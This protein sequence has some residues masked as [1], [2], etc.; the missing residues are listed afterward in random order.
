MPPTEKHQQI[1]SARTGK[2][3]GDLHRWINDPELQF[4]R[5]DV[6]RAWEF[7]PE[8]KERFGEE[9]VGEY[10][11]HLRIDMEMKLTNIWGGTT[12]VRDA[13]LEYFGI[14]KKTA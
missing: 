9:A 14:R 6:T 7:I 5:H 1:S 10:F 3:Y 4:A 8:V 12:E 13:A 11:E 2:D